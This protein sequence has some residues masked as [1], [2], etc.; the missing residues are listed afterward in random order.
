MRP[1]EML[2]SPFCC[3][4]VKASSVMKHQIMSERVFRLAAVHFVNVLL[5]LAVEACM[6]ALI[7]LLAAEY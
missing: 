7:R 5:S 4:N 6:K 3:F 2:C 1:D